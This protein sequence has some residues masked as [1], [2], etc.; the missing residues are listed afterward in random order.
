[1]EDAAGLDA[2]PATKLR[3]EP[4]STQQKMPAISVRGQPFISK[5]P[6][7]LAA[8]SKIDAPHRT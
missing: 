6:N 8:K 3:M 1:M 4:I 7:D 5:T 2:R